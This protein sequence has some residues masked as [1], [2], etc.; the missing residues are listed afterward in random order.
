M[1]CGLGFGLK[2]LNDKNAEAYHSRI[3]VRCELCQVALMSLRITGLWNKNPLLNWKSHLN[4]Q[5][6]LN[7]LKSQFLSTLSPNQLNEY[8]NTLELLINT[9]NTENCLNLY[10]EFDDSENQFQDQL[11]VQS[12]NQEADIYKCGSRSIFDQLIVLYPKDFYHQIFC[13]S[14]CNVAHLSGLMGGCFVNV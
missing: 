2:F 10:P 11:D 13:C 7:K 12:V 1:G 6:H 9:E 3:F 4:S 8:N 5:T 14:H